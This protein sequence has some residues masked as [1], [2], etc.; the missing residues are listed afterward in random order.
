MF[1]IYSS[2][3]WL[4]YNK[5]VIPSKSYTFLLQKVIRRFREHSSSDVILLENELKRVINYKE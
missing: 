4:H 5:E 2:K 3:T 1:D